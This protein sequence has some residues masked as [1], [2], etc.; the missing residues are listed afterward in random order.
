MREVISNPAAGALRRADPQRLPA[1]LR[2]VERGKDRW[3]VAQV[4]AAC[5][6]ILTPLATGRKARFRYRTSILQAKVSLPKLLDR[7][8]TGPVSL[9][10][11]C[12]G[13]WIWDAPAES[14]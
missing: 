2:W 12:G 6:C 3:A 1:D 10:R 5:C 7:L 14:S 4:A 8:V 9:K 11:R 13:T